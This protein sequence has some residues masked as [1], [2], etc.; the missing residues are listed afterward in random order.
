MAVA[1]AVAGRPSIPPGDEPT[2]NLDSQNGEAA[3]RLPGPIDPVIV[4]PGGSAGARR[5]EGAV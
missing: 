5:R 1:P 3:M 2:G 4:R